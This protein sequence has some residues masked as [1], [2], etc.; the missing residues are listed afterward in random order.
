MPTLNRDT[1][2]T[3]RFKKEKV[4]LESLGGIVYVRQLSGMER[5][6]YERAVSAEKDS[7][8]QAEMAVRSMARLII[9]CLVDD[10]GRNLLSLGDLQTVAD[11]FP[12]E[13]LEMLFNICLRQNGLNQDELQKTVKN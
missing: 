6:Q 8:S 9:M 10:G 13:E 3:P 1:L 11:S 4:E 5:V 2:L 7:D 12:F